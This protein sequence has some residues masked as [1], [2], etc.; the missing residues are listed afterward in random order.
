MML[1][2]DGDW[3]FELEKEF[4]IDDWYALWQI[5]LGRIAFGVAALYLAA[6]LLLFLRVRHSLALFR[7][8]AGAAIASAVVKWYVA[9][10]P[11]GYSGLMYF[12]EA[13]GGLVSCLV[14][15]GFLLLLRRDRNSAQS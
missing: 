7:I 2:P 5:D 8:A 15:V 1:N 10:W 6:S 3:V 14:N 12:I 13:S 11:G 4:H 9:S